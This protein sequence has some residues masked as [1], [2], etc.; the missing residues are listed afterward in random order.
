MGLHYILGSPIEA[1]HYS[2]TLKLIGKETETAFKAKVA[3][4]DES[5]GSLYKAGKC[6]TIPHDAFMAQFVDEDTFKYSLEIRNLK[7]EAK[8]DNYESGI[9]DNDDDSKE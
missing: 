9:S 3:S 2:Y 5:F 1:K 8:D 4:I 7:E 6:F